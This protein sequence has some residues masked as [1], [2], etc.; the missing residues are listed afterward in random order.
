[1][2]KLF[3]VL[4]EN[5]ENLKLFLDI[6]KEKQEA[7]IKNDA[8]ILEKLIV[9]EERILSEIDDIRIRMQYE[10]EAAALEFNFRLEHNFLKELIEKMKTTDNHEVEKLVTYQSSIRWL[11]MQINDINAQNKV[12]IEN[13]RK[14]VKEIISIITSENKQL[15]DRK[16]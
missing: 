2:K 3:E 5:E 9:I 6:V 13:S 16:A 12:L 10:V 15:L 11:V 8:D 4:S 14:F 1:M 7:L